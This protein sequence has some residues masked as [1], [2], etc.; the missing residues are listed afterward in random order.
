MQ[1]SPRVTPGNTVQLTPNVANLLKVIGLFITVLCSI[2]TTGD[3][4][5]CIKSSV[6]HT[7]LPPDP[8]LVKSSIVRS[9]GAPPII[10]T[11][12]AIWI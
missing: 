4:K 11:L 2:G 5:P 8:M 1:P 9:A 10:D 12:G 7:I 3:I 6:A